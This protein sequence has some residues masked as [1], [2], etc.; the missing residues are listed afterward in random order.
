MDKLKA[1]LSKPLTLYILGCVAVVVIS[2]LE[3]IHDGAENFITYRDATIAFF[4]GVS[5]Y[6]SDFVESHG[7]FFLYAPVFHYLFAPFAYLPFYAGGYLWN[8]AGWTAFFFAIKTLPGTL[9]ECT[10]PLVGYL[11][12]FVMQ[13]VFCFQY[14]ILVC[15]IFLYAFTLLE[16]DKPF[17]AVLLIM[18]SATTKIYG[19]IELALL[20]CYPKFWRNMGYA[21]LCGI[22]LLL[23]PITQTGWD[24]LVAWYMDWIDQLTTHTENTCSY[25]SLIWAQ[26]AQAFALAHTRLVQGVILG[27]LAILFVACRRRWQNY[28]FKVGVL[29]SL[30]IY[31]VLL[32]EAAEF[33]THTISVTGF[34]LWYFLKEKHT[35][36]EKIIL[37]G[38]FVLFGVM[39]IDIF[40]P[41]DWCYFVHKVLW[42]GVWVFTLCWGYLVYETVHVCQN[43]SKTKM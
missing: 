24:G 9:H 22:G 2:T 1:I 21:V 41:A 7:R 42:L 15:C 8:L 36:L 3:F 28:A 23:L 43:G 25:I 14:N 6:T 33:T 39:P 13:S 34:A 35:T 19:G 26:P 30:M 18:L 32:S 12:L 17:W 38:L 31:I 29:A 4:Q 10:T 37:W 11:L 16:N 5:S 40:F 20:L 27:G